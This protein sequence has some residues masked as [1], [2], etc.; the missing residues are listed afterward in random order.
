M[1]MAKLENVDPTYA[2]HRTNEADAAIEAA[3]AT[4]KDNE[5]KKKLYAPFLPKKG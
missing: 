5:A 1:T 3:K 4:I 2:Q